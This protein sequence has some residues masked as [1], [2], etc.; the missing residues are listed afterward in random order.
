MEAIEQVRR[1][2]YCIATW[3]P[4]VVAIATPLEVAGHPPLVL[5]FSVRTTDATSEISG[6][7]AMP[8]LQLRDAIVRAMAALDPD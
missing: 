5:N 2:G 3:Q 4:E 8:L 6:T 7:L 1:L